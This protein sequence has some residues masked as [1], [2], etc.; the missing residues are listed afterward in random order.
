MATLL[1]II[2]LVGTDFGPAGGAVLGP[3]GGR[4]D[5]REGADVTKDDSPVIRRP[6]PGKRRPAVRRRERANLRLVEDLRAA[7]VPPPGDDLV[8]G[9]SVVV[10]SYRGAGHLMACLESLAAQTLAPDL[11]DVVVV[12]NGPRDGS[13]EVLAG[14]A[15]RHPLLSLQVVELADRA[16]VGV[17]RNAGISVSGRQFMALVDD[18]DT[19]SAGY[20][21]ALL[22]R[23][24]PDVVPLARLVDVAPSGEVDQDTAFSAVLARQGDQEFEADRAPSLLSLNACRMLATELVRR[25][26][27]DP[28]LRSGVD[29]A[30]MAE[31]Y[32]A[33]R[34]RLVS[35][36]PEADATYF[37][38]VRPGSVSR[39][40]YD[41][42]FS[43]GGR[44]DV[45]ERI[46]PHA[47]S[48]H[49]GTATVARTLAAA[50]AG[51]MRRYLEERPDEREAV[52][53]AIRSRGLD[54]FPYPAL[55]RD[56]ARRLLVSYCFTPYAGP[57]CI[58]S[59]K[60][61]HE[62]GEVVDVV[63]NAMDA[64]RQVDPGT[65]AIAEEYVDRK[66]VLATRT[67]FAKWSAVRDFC[68]EGL[69]A[70]EAFEAGKDRAYESL[71]SRAMW[72]ASHFLAARYKIRHP[73]VRWTAEFSDPVST[74]VHGR[75][76]AGRVRDDPL[77]REL[78]AALP[79]DFPGDRLTLFQWCE[80]IAYHLADELMFT[81]RNQLQVMLEECPPALRDTVR[82]KAVVVPQPVLPPRFY[83]RVSVESPAVPGVAT[84]AYFGAFYPTRGLGEVFEALASLDDRV[85]RSLRLHVYTAGVEPVR[86]ALAG[87]PFADVVE[88]REYRPYLEFLALTTRY[89][90]LLVND[91]TTTGTGHPVNP[92]LPSKYSDYRGSGTPVWGHVEPG[93]VLSGEDLDLVSTVGDVASVREVLEQIVARAGLSGRPQRS[94]R[95]SSTSR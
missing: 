67:V 60:R 37:R 18:D 6:A 31:I 57:S 19:V 5:Q 13:R 46:A 74:D 52:L 41:F 2:G 69:A 64:V 38:S 26:G 81:N 50:Q 78:R 58:V 22:D 68:D 40:D 42:G 70:V 94:A 35:V 85:R 51:F 66:A 11:F 75:P 62:R 17:A 34:F 33:G 28:D 53:E 56:A 44:L 88:V 49:A 89:D 80:Q 23:A 39:Q 21:E 25:V 12:L 73:Q 61:V 54:W 93:S 47:L 43:I 79:G 1:T 86:Q 15:G 20:L 16:G 90:A 87:Q 83:Q 3:W 63:L 82:A 55:N 59:A 4:T 76:R 32:A 84:I 14:V 77:S 72:P 91:A 8:P 36:P 65:E 30:F 10:P 48:P 24:A 7:G 45:I 29:V 27:Y 95:R 9:V 92:Y 71:H